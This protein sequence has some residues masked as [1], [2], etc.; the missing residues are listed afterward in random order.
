MAN[1]LVVDDEL[2]IRDLLS[3]ILNDEGH[4]VD[5]AENAAQARAAELSALLPSADV[6]SATSAANDAD[7][8]VQQVLTQDE[9]IGASSGAA[10]RT[11]AQAQ[12]QVLSQVGSNRSTAITTS[13]GSG[14][15]DNITA[16]G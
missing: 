7:A 13:T 12:V 2:G 3:E 14:A 8:R 10:W 4:N 5:L 16:R 15:G 9:A 1:I 6:A 11:Y